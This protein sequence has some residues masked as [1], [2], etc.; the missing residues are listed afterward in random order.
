M[1]LAHSFQLIIYHRLSGV[2]NCHQVQAQLSVLEMS[3]SQLAHEQMRLGLL[4][5]GPR[6]CDLKELQLVLTV[7]LNLME[8]NV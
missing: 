2:L 1:S 7:R 8:V 6:I 4:S 3:S 5:W